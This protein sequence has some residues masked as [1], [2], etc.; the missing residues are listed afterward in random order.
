MNYRA[1]LEVARAGELQVIIPQLSS[2]SSAHT[3]PPR[4][5]PRHCSKE[6][7]ERFKNV[8]SLYRNLTEIRDYGNDNDLDVGGDGDSSAKPCYM[9]QVHIEYRLDKPD[10]GKFSSGYIVRNKPTFST[11]FAKTALRL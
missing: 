8:V 11:I 7:Q 1:A 9:L 2:N 10:T 3:K 6:V 5:I 4:G